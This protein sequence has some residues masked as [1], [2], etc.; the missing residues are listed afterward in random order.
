MTKG[1]LVEAALSE[2]G[3]SSYE[4]DIS[5]EEITAGIRRMDTLIAQWS[6]KGL[7]LNYPF[8]EL[9]GSTESGIPD[10]ALEAVTTNLAVRLSPSYGKQPSPSL[11]SAARA[12]M[13]AVYS[14]STR[15][16]EI[17]FPQ[18]PRGAG[19]KDREHPFTPVPDSPYLDE[20]DN[21]VD[22]S[23]GPDG[24]T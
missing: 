9:D 24:G 13:T 15:P 4:F 19:H 20:V 5:P 6:S 11:L 14:T 12:A 1:E 18:M 2:L 10:V 22:L 8:G 7:V 16:R 21:D 17:Q 3:I 23:G